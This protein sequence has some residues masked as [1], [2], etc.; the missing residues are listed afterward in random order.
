[1]EIAVM[2]YSLGNN[3]KKKTH[4]RS[5]QTQF[6][7]THSPKKASRCLALSFLVSHPM[8]V[9]HYFRG[10]LKL[11][12]PKTLNSRELTGILCI[13]LTPVSAAAAQHRSEPHSSGRHRPLA[14]I[15]SI[16]TRQS[17]SL[18]RTERNC[19][20]VLYPFI[21]WLTALALC[22]LWFP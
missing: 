2:L 14:V 5:V 9:S 8:W 12:P 1:M 15:K 10:E 3:Y 16:C 4:M 21:C 7:G 13:L 11:W 17:R 22:K 18:I 6:L 19:S 20:P